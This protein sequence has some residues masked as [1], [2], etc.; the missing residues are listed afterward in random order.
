MASYDLV[1]RLT[2]T[3]RQIERNLLDLRDELSACRL[4]TARIFELPEV[5]KTSEHAPLSQIQVVQHL[6][7]LRWH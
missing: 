3:F 4:L 7:P 5:K 6:G 2:D 1:E